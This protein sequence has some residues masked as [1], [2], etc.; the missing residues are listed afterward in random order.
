[1]KRRPTSS[2]NRLPSVSNAKLAKKYY[3]RKAAQAE[4]HMRNVFAE[5]HN[6]TSP[7][8]NERLH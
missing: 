2:P 7:A 8:K 3:L 5:L 4:K 6:L 1:M